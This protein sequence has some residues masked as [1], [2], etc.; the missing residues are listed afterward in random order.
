MTERGDHN[1]PDEAKRQRPEEDRPT[2]EPSVVPPA[3]EEPANERGGAAEPDALA[4]LR[5]E[6]ER[7]WEQFRTEQE[8]AVRRLSGGPGAAP[9]AG[10][11]P[12]AAGEVPTQPATPQ[13]GPESTERIPYAQEY[14]QQYGEQPSAYGQRPGY[15]QPQGGWGGPPGGQG[16][17]PQPGWGSPYPQGYPAYQVRQ[18]EPTAI[19]AFVL[20]ITS[21][22]ICPVL[23]A[24]VALVLASNAKRAIAESRGT[25]DGEG[26]ATAAQVISWI[27]LALA[28]LVLLLIIFAIAAGTSTSSSVSSY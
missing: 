1:G 24:I 2:P 8:E 22:V 11:R 25:K 19:W 26:L 14:Q 13:A 6:Q 3:A 4:R 5:Q 9:E 7:R 16:G 23:P 10:E 21:Y 18:T 15:G 17:V 20:S 12:P 28:A 27:H